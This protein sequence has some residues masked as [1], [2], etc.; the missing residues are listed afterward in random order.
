MSD[1]NSAIGVFD[2]G[3]GG[4]TAIKQLRKI[5]PDERFI[6]FG[7]TGRVPYGTRSF[8]TIKQY[9]KDDL[10]FL[11]GF[12]IKAAV[13]ACGT[14]SAIALDSLEKDFG[15]PIVGAI[16]PACHA[17]VLATQNSKIAVFATPA[18]IGNG[19]F[20]RNLKNIDSSLEVF[21]VACPMFVPL[22]ES[23]YVSK[24]CKV[25]RII[26]AEYIEKLKNTGIDTLILGCTHYPII[27]PLLKEV[28]EEILGH[29]ISI[30]DSGHEAALKTKEVLESADLISDTGCGKTE[31]FVSDETQNFKKIASMFLGE[32]AENVTKVSIG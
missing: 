19:A 4:L 5:L 22:I 14:V 15:L 16:K 31:Y 2:S 12:D 10:R 23:G 17:A 32:T 24:D 28:A 18:T 27:A 11:T 20:E 7:D 9:A 29:E 8:E 3:L 6:Y 21:P 25:T 30:I 13:V 26:A 1:K